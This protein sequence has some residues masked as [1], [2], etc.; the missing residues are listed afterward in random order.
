METPPVYPTIKAD[1]YFT[2]KNYPPEV[3]NM[4]EQLLEQLRVLQ[5]EY[6]RAADPIHDQLA[7][8]ED[9]ASITYVRKT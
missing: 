7:R 8:L 9:Y 2:I 4:R 1:D 6:Q 5:I 3:E